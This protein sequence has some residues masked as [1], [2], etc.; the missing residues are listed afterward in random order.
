MHGLHFFIS[1]QGVLQCH[2]ERAH[3]LSRSCTHA[4]ARRAKRTKSRSLSAP[5]G[6][7]LRCGTHT[8][9]HACTHA[10]MHAITHAG[11]Q[12]HACTRTCIC[13]VAEVA[14]YR[15]RRARP[16]DARFRRPRWQR[17]SLHCAV[18]S[19]Q[20]FAAIAADLTPA[21][22]P[23]FDALRVVIESPRRANPAGA[24]AASRT[25]IE[26]QGLARVAGSTGLH[27]HVHPAWGLEAGGFAAL[28]MHTWCRE[29]S[30]TTGDQLL[31]IDGRLSSTGTRATAHRRTP[32]GLTATP[33]PLRAGVVTA[34]VHAQAVGPE[35]AATIPCT[36]LTFTAYTKGG[37]GYED[38]QPLTE[39]RK[40]NVR[41]AIPVRR[42]A[43]VPPSA[44]NRF[45]GR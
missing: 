14:P 10:C 25:W 9:F 6:G 24:W 26:Q 23:A 31:D 33:W 45:T 27:H 17:A 29:K 40:S 19:A 32:A 39:Q 11:I 2:A 5:Q 13:A 22:R 21:L 1:G 34:M 12:T 43:P 41:H 42:S 37:S 16:L 38:E 18:R 20:V 8:H 28:R 3:T 35:A 7:S 15:R 4:T 44:R 30:Q 36:D